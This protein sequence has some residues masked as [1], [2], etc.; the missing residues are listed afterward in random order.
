MKLSKRN[1]TSSEPLKLLPVTDSE[2]LAI[3]EALK[4]ASGKLTKASGTDTPEFISMSEV[5]DGTGNLAQ[6]IRIEKDMEFKTTLYSA[7][8]AAGTIVVGDK[9][10]LHTDGSQVTFTTANGVAEVL[11]FPEGTKY[12]GDEVIVK[13]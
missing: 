2:A 9:V 11:G 7:T 10:T 1:I 8:T 12:N 6:A 13:F 3:G 4:L 5:S